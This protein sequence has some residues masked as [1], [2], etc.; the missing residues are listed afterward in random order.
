[1]RL[2]EAISWGPRWGRRL[3]EKRMTMTE[4]HELRAHSE[5]PPTD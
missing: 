5:Q 4:K 2:S 3:L 1:M